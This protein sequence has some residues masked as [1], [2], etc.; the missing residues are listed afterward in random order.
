MLRIMPCVALG[1]VASFVLGREGE[2]PAEPN[3]ALDFMFVQ[4]SGSAGALPSQQAKPFEPTAEEITIFDLTNKERKGKDL[5]ALVLNPALN[6]IARAHS[7]N[8][9]QQKKMEHKLDGKESKERVKEA[10]YK[11][12]RVGE[13]IA[14]GEKGAQIPR[15]M[16]AWME[17]DGHRKNILSGEYAEIGVGIAGITQAH[18]TSPR[19]S[20]R[21][22]SR[23]GAARRICRF[24]LDT[25]RPS[26]KIAMR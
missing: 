7:E 26:R 1:L 18:F 25:A 4:S 13:N 12:T 17:S 21:R 16:K 22:A 15:I 19:F 10:G 23:L 20:P 11:F 5:P 3:A 6:K 9:A 14:M 24:R 2:A 8:M